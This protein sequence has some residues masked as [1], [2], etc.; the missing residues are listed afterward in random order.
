MLAE[1]RDPRL[2]GSRTRRIENVKK[3]TTP[4]ALT[5]C[6]I[7]LIGSS[8]GAQEKQESTPAGVTEEAIAE[9]EALFKGAGICFTCHGQDAKGVPGL[10]ADLTDTE[11]VH[12]D[13]TYE[14]IIETIT[15]GTTSSTGAVMP[16]RGGPNL[17]DEQ[18]KALA[19]YVWSLSHKPTE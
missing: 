1:R 16:P 9:G 14:S 3:L 11:W 13:G 15:K 5:A 17:T 8:A 6:A 19:A 4:L 2:I 10:G 12:S 18:V 7:A